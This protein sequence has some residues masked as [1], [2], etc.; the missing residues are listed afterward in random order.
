MKWF[1]GFVVRPFLIIFF[2]MAQMRMI[3]FKDS[4][5]SNIIFISIGVAP[6]GLLGG[7]VLNMK[8]EHIE[9][10]FHLAVDQFAFL[11]N[12]GFFC[13]N[14]IFLEEKIQSRN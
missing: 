14:H 11:I 3:I 12:S 8:N 2:F 4:T 1:S 10:K 13:H 6:K 9:A 5:R 7:E